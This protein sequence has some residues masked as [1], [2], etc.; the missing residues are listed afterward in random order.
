MQGI[1]AAFRLQRGGFTLDAELSA[2]P[3]GVTALFG[4]SGCGK[5]TLLRCLAGLERGIGY[6]QVNGESWQ[7][8]HHFTPPHGRSIGYVFQEPSLFTHLSV[9]RNLEYGWKDSG[10]SSRRYF[11][12]VTEWLGVEPMLARNPGQLSGGERQRVAIARALLRRP[13]VLL[14]DEPL[15]A[16]DHGSKRAIL[17]YLEHLRDELAIPVVYVSHDPREVA[18]LADN[19]VMLEQGRVLEAGP[20]ANLL[21][22]LDLPLAH[23]DN[24]SA[25]LEGEVSGHDDTYHLTWISMH[26]GRFT[27]PREDVKIGQRARIQVFASDV[28]IALSAHHDTSILNIIPVR[29]ADIG[30]ANPAQLLV[31]LELTD[32]QSLLARLTRRSGAALNL[33]ENQIVYAQVKSVALFN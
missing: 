31:R 9:H 32:G 21:T 8:E 17:P 7:N 29:I 3:N 27:V 28:S 1:E 6:C 26:G 13:Q 12:Q 11:R 15:S 30:E 22:R 4:H 18:Q 19:V 16:L 10:E 14:M 33:R 5:T 23:F 25:I 2:P 20:I 24:A